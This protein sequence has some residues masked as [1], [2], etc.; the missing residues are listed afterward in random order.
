M[1]G[2][3]EFNSLKMYEKH[4]KLNRSDRHVN[5]KTLIILKIF[6]VKDCFSDVAM[7]LCA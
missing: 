3:N 6:T 2:T 5:F 1:D 7:M 4:I